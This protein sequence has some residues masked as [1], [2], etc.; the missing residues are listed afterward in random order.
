MQYDFGKVSEH[1][2]PRSSA[3]TACMYYYLSGQTRSFSGRNPMVV[4]E[5]CNLLFV[6][7]FSFG[8]YLDT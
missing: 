3:I 4:R 2:N 6:L 8:T 7:V 1:I 5:L